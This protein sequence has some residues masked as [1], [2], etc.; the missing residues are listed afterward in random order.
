MDVL[1]EASDYVDGGNYDQSGDLDPGR[2][3]CGQTCGWT[4]D[5]C[6]DYDYDHDEIAKDRIRHAVWQMLPRG[7]PLRWTCRQQAGRVQGL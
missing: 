2:S 6:A 3:S 1:E 7:R 5:Y 4:C